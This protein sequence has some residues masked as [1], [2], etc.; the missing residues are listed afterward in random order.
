MDFRNFPFLI[1]IPHR[2]SV[3]LRKKTSFFCCPTDTLHY[4]TIYPRIPLPKGHFEPEREGRKARESLALEVKIEGGRRRRLLDKWRKRTFHP[5][6]AHN[7]EIIVTEVKFV[8]IFLENI[9]GAG[10]L[11]SKIVKRQK[12]VR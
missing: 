6:S 8:A 1:Q 5:A 4:C 10:S 7:V 3:Y 12:I 9:L 11:Q 2:V